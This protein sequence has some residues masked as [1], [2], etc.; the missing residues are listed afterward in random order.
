V[1][2]CALPIWMPCSSTLHRCKAAASDV[3]AGSGSA[4]GQ[5]A[6]AKA[7]IDR[8]RRPSRPLAG[9]R[10]T[11]VARAYTTCVDDDPLYDHPRC[12]HPELENV[13][14]SLGDPMSRGDAADP[15]RDG[16]LP[17][18]LRCRRRKL[19]SLRWHV[20]ERDGDPQRLTWLKI[21]RRCAVQ[22]D[23]D[24]AGRIQVDVVL[25]SRRSEEH[26][27]ELQSRENLVCRLLL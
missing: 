27:S 24:L 9:R 11:Q 7:G 18:F 15:I 22:L 1:Q 25:E 20:V 13:V 14:A 12:H 5:T 8:C 2:T 23:G 10:R 17:G 19:D 3:T 6:D 21:Q 26:T 4:S 16:R